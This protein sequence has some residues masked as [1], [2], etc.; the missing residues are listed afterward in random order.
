MPGPNQLTALVATSKLKLGHGGSTGG[1]MFHSLGTYRG[2]HI[3]TH[4]VHHG[5]QKD[6]IIIQ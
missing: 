2:I 5:M 1:T 4:V 6:L 3:S